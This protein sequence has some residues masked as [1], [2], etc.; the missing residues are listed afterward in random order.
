MRGK[1]GEIILGTATKPQGRFWKVQEK[2]STDEFV[3]DF[4]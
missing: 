4:D 1:L 2:E 3:G